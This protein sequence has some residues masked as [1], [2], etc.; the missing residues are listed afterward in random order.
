MMVSMPKTKLRLG[1]DC[2]GDKGHCRN[3]THYKQADHKRA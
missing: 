1:Q 2:T 3:S